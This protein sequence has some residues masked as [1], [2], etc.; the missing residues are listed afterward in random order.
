MEQGHLE[1]HL[2]DFFSFV[3]FA[4]FFARSMKKCCSVIYTFQ[5]SSMGNFNQHL[6]PEEIIA[7]DLLYPT[8]V[9]WLPDDQFVSLCT[10]SCSSL[11]FQVQ[12]G[13]CLGRNFQKQTLL[14]SANNRHLRENVNNL[15]RVLR[16]LNQ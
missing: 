8:F 4:N 3:D 7:I 15:L 11:V 1:L 16:V 10:F 13:S 2:S 5:C 12:L 6:Y 9:L 14:L